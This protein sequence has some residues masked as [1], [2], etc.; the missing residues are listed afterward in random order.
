MVKAVPK[1]ATEERILHAAMEVFVE[2]GRHGARMQEIADRAGINKAL[3]HYYFRNKEKLYAKIFES[4]IWEN[5]SGIITLLNKDM[6]VRE[7]LKT[8]ISEYIDLLARKPKIPLF[9]LKELS[10]GGETVKR[11]LK[12]LVEKGNFSVNGPLEKIQ[13][14]RDRGEIIA[15]DPRQLIST[16]I[17]AC[18]IY[19]ISQPIFHTLFIREENFNQQK[20]IEER[21]EAVYQ[22]ILQGILPRSN[23]E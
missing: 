12:E 22:I 19:F 18:L 1:E 21:K 20:F 13:S 16:I 15:V 7:Y 2:K 4:L 6:P 23:T 8:F 11:V 17:G 5:I 3:L 10:E 14:A 9:I